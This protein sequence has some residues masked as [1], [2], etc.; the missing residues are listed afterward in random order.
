M[1]T[2]LR[3]LGR[4]KQAQGGALQGL[5]SG[6][7]KYYIHDHVRLF[8]LQLLGSL[9]A[10]DMHELDGCWKT[11][12]SSVA[13][14]RIQIDISNLLA[15]DEAGRNWLAQLAN[16]P[17]LDFLAAPES[18]GFLPAGVAMEIVS[19][20]A[21]TLAG[22]WIGRSM[23]ALSERRRQ[24]PGEAPSEGARAIAIDLSSSKTE[25]STS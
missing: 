23:G 17:N 15:A 1:M 8:R 18:A 6:R 3:T 7:L 25:I 4:R 13:G 9:S 5:A 19:N 10:L 12:H 21:A 20:P 2:R 24:Q 11:A 22:S 16:T 14:R